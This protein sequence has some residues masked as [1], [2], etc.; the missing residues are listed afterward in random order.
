MSD[1]DDSV[2]GQAGPTTTATQVGTTLLQRQAPPLQRQA[3]EHRRRQAD[4]LMALGWRP[5]PVR[6]WRRAIRDAQLEHCLGPV[7]GVSTGMWV[8]AGWVTV[9]ELVWRQRNLRNRLG[10]AKRKMTAQEAADVA[11]KLIR[12]RWFKSP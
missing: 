4:K 9:F 12:L 1:E 5:V 8:P 2:G 10:L 11:V 3:I 7:S 6:R